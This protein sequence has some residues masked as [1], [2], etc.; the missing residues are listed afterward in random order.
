MKNGIKSNALNPNQYLEESSV[1]V[2]ALVTYIS[3]LFS[4]LGS[5]Y[6]QKF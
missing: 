5:N 1:Y 4:I 3:Y 6:S 2:M